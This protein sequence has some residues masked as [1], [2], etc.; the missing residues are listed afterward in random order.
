MARPLQEHEMRLLRDMLE[1]ASLQQPKLLM[2]L[3]SVLVEEMDDGGMGSLR[4]VGGPNEERRLGAT[5]AE[6]EFRD[7]DGVYVSATI[8]VDHSGQLYELDLWKADFTALK[9][10]PK[11]DEVTL[12]T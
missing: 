9:R 12:K 4:F 3:E 11:V 2:D 5:V 1:R 8:S 6:A 10:W 7:E